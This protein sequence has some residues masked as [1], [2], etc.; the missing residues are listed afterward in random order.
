LA[1]TFTPFADLG[2]ACPDFSLPGI[3]GK[4]HSLKELSN[5]KPLVIAFI[6]V[7]CPYVQAIESRLVQLGHDL[8]KQNVNMVAICSND[9]KDHPEDSFEGM[10]QRAAEHGYSFLYLHDEDQAV[11]RQFGAVCTPDYFVYDKN[12]KLSYRGR[13]DDSWKD[14]NKVTKRE[15]YE[16][17]QGL[18]RDE[19]IS[20][21]QIAS[22]GCSIKWI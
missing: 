8:K 17:V 4:V 12:L 7:H 15:L 20:D 10:K 22:M 5:D 14:A 18:L 1:L 19:K 2:N 9:A 21:E 16:A 11:A 6:C 13:L 3:D